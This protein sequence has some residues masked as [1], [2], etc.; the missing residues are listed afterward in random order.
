MKKELIIN[1][2][3]FKVDTDHIAGFH[4]ELGRKNVKLKLKNGIEIPVPREMIRQEGEKI[5]LR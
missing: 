4:F 1:G 3:K 5:E 2:L